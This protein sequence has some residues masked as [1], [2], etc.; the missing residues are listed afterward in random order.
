MPGPYPYPY[1]TPTPTA[2]R[3]PGV[4]APSCCTCLR[5]SRARSACRASCSPSSR[6][7][8]TQPNNPKASPKPQHHSQ[9]PTKANTGALRFYEKHGYTVDESSPSRCG[10]PPNPTPTPIP[11]LTLTLTRCGVPGS[12]YEIMCKEVGTAAPK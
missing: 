5:S 1:P 2:T 4:W 10:V 7:T 12:T 6:R 8:Q 9:T 3:T 11:T